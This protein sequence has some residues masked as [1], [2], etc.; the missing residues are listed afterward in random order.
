MNYLANVR[1][2]FHITFTVYI[3]TLVFMC[4]LF[5]QLYIYCTVYKAQRLHECLCLIDRDLFPLSHVH[6]S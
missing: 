1:T 4:V 6:E 2:Q 5:L 3:H